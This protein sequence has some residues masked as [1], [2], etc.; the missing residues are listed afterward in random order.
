MEYIILVAF[1]WVLCFLIIA[2][3]LQKK[4]GSLGKAG[5]KRTFR[6]WGVMCIFFVLVIMLVIKAFV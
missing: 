5:F 6:F 4:Y 2:S 1:L 3:I